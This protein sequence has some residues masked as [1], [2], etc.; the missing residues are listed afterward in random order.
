MSIRRQLFGLLFI[1]VGIFLIFSLSHDVQLL[2]SA[3]DRFEREYDEVIKLE[4]EQQ[5]LAQE[6]LDVSSDEFVEEEAR[7][8]LLM[9]KPDEVVVLLPESRQATSSSEPVLEIYSGEKPIANWR[10][11]LNLFL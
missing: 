8:K 2:L 11:W 5:R 10:K 4:E 1:L 9:S 7:N 6:L 3:R